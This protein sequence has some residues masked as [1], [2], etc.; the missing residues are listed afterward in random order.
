MAINAG[1]AHEFYHA[2]HVEPACAARNGAVISG[3]KERAEARVAQG[4]V[5]QSPSETPSILT[6]N[7]LAGVMST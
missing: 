7:G 5:V 4:C 3:R 1:E 2:R 6:W